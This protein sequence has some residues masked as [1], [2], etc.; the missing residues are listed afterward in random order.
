MKGAGELRLLGVQVVS[1][2]AFLSVFQL[3][4]VEF[5]LAVIKLPA[6]AGYGHKIVRA[7]IVLV[8][9]LLLSK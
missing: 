2:L 6:L 3:A 5:I 8:T 9:I 7:V 4:S 1:V